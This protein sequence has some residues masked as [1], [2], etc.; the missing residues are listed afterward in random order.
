MDGFRFDFTK[1][2]TNLPGDGGAYD[3]SR[4][5]ILRRMANEIWSINDQAYVI[6]E[7]LADNT[8]EKVLSEYG[9]MLW[10]NLNYNY[11]EATMGYHENA[12]SDFS[13]IS[14]KKGGGRSRAWW[15]IWKAMTRND[16]C[17]RI[18]TIGNASGVYD[19]QDL[20]YRSQ[21]NGAGRGFLLS[22]FPVPK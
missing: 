15:D 7:H 16:S 22:P 11:N 4:I 19:I 12:K 14:N 3:V 18:W 20:R 8:E 17:T 9:M 21:E 13:W 10:G 5:A 2:F 1:G 6:L